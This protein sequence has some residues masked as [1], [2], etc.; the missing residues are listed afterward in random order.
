MVAKLRNVSQQV[1]S[2]L[3]C[4][5]VEMQVIPKGLLLVKLPFK[6]KYFEVPT[7]LIS[8]ETYFCMEVSVVMQP[9]ISLVLCSKNGSLLKPR[10]VFLDKGVNKALFRSHDPLFVI[11]TQRRINEIS[12]VKY[13]PIIIPKGNKIS[14]IERRVW[15]GSADPE[16]FFCRSCGQSFAQYPDAHKHPTGNSFCA[17]VPSLAMVKLPERLEKFQKAVLEAKKQTFAG[18]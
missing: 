16:R 13:M 14:L 11:A 1:M 9:G 5:N 4:L 10:E 6:G 8:R 18:L 7:E 17:G 12:V 2:E 3:L 15:L